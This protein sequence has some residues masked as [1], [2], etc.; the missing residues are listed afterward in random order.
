MTPSK[1]S[2]DD[3]SL[4]GH[5]AQRKRQHGDF[6]SPKT[7]EGAAEHRRDVQNSSVS[8]QGTLD[9][10]VKRRESKLAALKKAPGDARNMSPAQLADNYVEMHGVA[11]AQKRLNALRAKKNP[12]AKDKALISALSGAVLRGVS[13]RSK[14]HGIS[15]FSGQK[16]L[17]YG[18]Y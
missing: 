16:A 18:R 13:A 10:A 1:F 12:T 2:E 3:A 8:K 9:Q 4:M 5:L 15:Q 7:A 17:G 6:R 11:G 14:K